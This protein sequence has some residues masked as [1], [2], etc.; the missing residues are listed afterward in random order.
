[1][2]DHVKIFWNGT[3]DE[4][5][6]ENILSWIPSDFKGR[7]LDVPA[8]TAV[9]TYRKWKSMV[10]TDITLLDYSEDMLEKAE[11]RLHECKHTSFMWEDA[12]YEMKRV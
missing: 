1:M 8:G 5:I 11:D 2:K 4:K 6:A 12:F 9:F 3:D 10:H 7:I